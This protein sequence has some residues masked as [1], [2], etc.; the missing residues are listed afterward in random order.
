M[1]CVTTSKVAILINGTRTSF[2]APSRGIRQGD[3][4]SPYLFIL[5][6]KMLSIKIEQAVKIKKMDPH[7]NLP[8]GSC[9]FTHSIAD[10]I[11]LISRADEANC[12]IILNIMDEFCYNS[13]KNINI[14]KFKVYFSKSCSTDLEDN[15]V[16]ILSIK[17]NLQLGEISGF[18][19][20]K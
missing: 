5:C 14:T 15:I 20:Y 6:M 8:E 10:D 13:G 7:Q 18:C 2:F 16:N 9:Y 1:S 4:L 11:I 17:K 3:P 12:N 19:N